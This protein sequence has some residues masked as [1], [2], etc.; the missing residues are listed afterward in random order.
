MGDDTCD[1]CGR[2][3]VVGVAS[4]ALGPVSWA[5]CRECLNKPADVACM[6]AATIDG[7]N[8][9]ANV[10]D[11]VKRLWAWE[12]GGY[13]SWS[14]FCARHEANILAEALERDTAQWDGS[15]EGQDA[16]G[17]LIGEADDSPVG[18]EGADAPKTPPPQDNHHDT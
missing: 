4:S 11:W 7:C 15:P 8:G 10:A 5:Y 16:E 17:G 2:G 6:F 14:D 1:V 9:S 18:P 12:D 13:V 3:G